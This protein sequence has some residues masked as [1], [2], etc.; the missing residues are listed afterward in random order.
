M[1]DIINLFLFVLQISVSPNPITIKQPNG[2]KLSII[3]KGNMHISYTETTDGYTL[4]KNKKGIYEYALINKTTGD[5]VPSGY[6]AHNPTRR[7]KKEVHFLRKIK[8]HNKYQPPKLDSLLIE[9][10]KFNNEIKN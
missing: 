2:T 3:G 4:V 8:K 7:S 6:S 5:L 9:Q 1:M 10:K